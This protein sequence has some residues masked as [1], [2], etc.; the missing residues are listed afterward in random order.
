MLVIDLTVIILAMIAAAVIVGLVRSS[1]KVTDADALLHE[2]K[3]LRRTLLEVETLAFQNKDFEPIL[4]DA[5]LRVVNKN[6][7]E[8]A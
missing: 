1:R 5:I 8:I 3:V 6:K 4:S 7:K 2:V